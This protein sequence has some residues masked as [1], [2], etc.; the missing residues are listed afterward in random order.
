MK[1]QLTSIYVN[2][3]VEAF[4]FYTEILGFKEQMFMPEA[5]LA[6]VVS[7][8]EPEGTAILLEPSDNPIAKEYMV[9][10]YEAGLPPIIFSVKDIQNEYKRLTKLDVEFK[11]KPT[12]MDWGWEAIFD[13]TCG[14]WIQLAQ[15]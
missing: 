13:D 11:K 6:I 9:K 12:Q 15:K 1:I 3:P 14:N 8:E 2:D 10:L 4:K 5:N 7:P